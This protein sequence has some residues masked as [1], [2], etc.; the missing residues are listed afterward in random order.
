MSRYRVN[1]VLIAIGSPDGDAI[2]AFNTIARL[3]AEDV[4]LSPPARNAFNSIFSSVGN[5]V[6]IFD[7]TMR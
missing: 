5:A 2:I 6:I 4:E 7:M 1:A 3:L